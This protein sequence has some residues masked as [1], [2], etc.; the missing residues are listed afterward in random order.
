MRNIN[1]TLFNG[2]NIQS[3][4]YLPFNNALRRLVLVQG[5]D[6]EELL[7]ILDDVEQF[8]DDKVIKQDLRELATKYLK[9]YQYD[10]TVRF[11]LLNYT[12]GAAHG[13]IKY[14]VEG[15]LGAWRKIYNRYVPLADDLQ[16][17]LIREFIAIKQVTETGVVNLSSEVDR[18]TEFYIKT[19]ESDPLQDKWVKAVIF[20]NLPDNWVITLSMQLR[21]AK[22]VAEM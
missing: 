17:I 16:H 2:R 4:P 10:R 7:D 5:K 9:V 3:N 13:R 11:T 19:G 22:T 18:I 6:G 21:H 14:G 12:T 1:I 8:G 20:H 15:G